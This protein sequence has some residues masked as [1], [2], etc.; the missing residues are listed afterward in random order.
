[1]AHQQQ[2]PRIQ[3][4]TLVWG[5]DQNGGDNDSRYSQDSRSDAGGNASGHAAQ[6]NSRP[7]H[8]RMNMA[9][10]FRQSSLFSIASESE[11][12]S[13]SVVDANEAQD[14]YVATIRTVI[15][16]LG[17]EALLDFS[18]DDRAAYLS[19]YPEDIEKLD[20]IRTSQRA[21]SQSPQRTTPL[22][23]PRQQ[24]LSSN[25]S[26]SKSARDS[27]Q[28]ST[29]VSQN[30][31]IKQ[32]KTERK[33]SSLS[34]ELA[35]LQDPNNNHFGN[36]ILIELRQGFKNVHEHLAN[37]DMTNQRLSARIDEMQLV[38]SQVGADLVSLSKICIGLKSSEAITNENQKT[39]EVNLTQLSSQQKNLKAIERTQVQ[40][41]QRAETAIKDLTIIIA[42]VKESVEDMKEILVKLIHTGQFVN[43]NGISTV[44]PMD[45]SNI[46]SSLNNSISLDDSTSTT[47]LI[48]APQSLSSLQSLIPPELLEPTAALHKV[49]A[50]PMAIATGSTTPPPEGFSSVNAPSSPTTALVM[51]HVA[52]LVSLRNSNPTVVD[53]GAT[54][55]IFN[56]LPSSAFNRKVAHDSYLTFGGDNKFTLKAA[57]T[58]STAIAKMNLL[59]KDAKINLISVPQ[60]DIKGI[61]TL[62]YNGIGIMWDPSTGLVHAT[63]T[64]KDMLYHLD[65]RPRCSSVPID[66][67]RFPRR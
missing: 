54:S 19:L 55:S 44:D 47:A 4:Q 28:D 62:F 26:S 31:K 34:K 67:S 51:Q 10:H 9:T 27:A 18:D 36:N 1:M 17:I 64:L 35:F 45:S 16:E 49:A 38:Q 32:E 6:H 11:S 41:M 46:A 25:T 3:Q 63:A 8:H 7:S 15:E 66:L 60:A 58:F 57:E 14:E 39:L 20:S 53:S 21:P 12:E 13:S 52:Q 40:R 22:S 2:P 65:E 43:G 30:L 23:D 33:I 56:Q 48:P 59:V 24:Q 42:E 5:D 61:A 37:L 50:L 29:S